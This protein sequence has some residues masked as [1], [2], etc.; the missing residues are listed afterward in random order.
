MPQKNEF[1]L[2]YLGTDTYHEYDLLYGAKGEFSV[3]IEITN[4]ITRYAASAVAYDEFHSIFTS[5]VKILG[6]G[7]LLQKQDVFS[8]VVYPYQEDDDYLQDKY[9]AHFAGREYTRISTYLT[10]T[11]QPKKGRF[12]VYD[13]KVLQE[14]RQAVTKVVSILGASKCHPSLLKK[15][16]INKLMISVL[17]MDFSGDSLVLDNIRPTDTELQMGS[18]ATRCI[19]LVNADNVDLPSEVGTHIEMNDKDTMKGFPVDV[20]NFLHKVPGYETIIYNQMIEIPSQQITLNKL[21]VKKKRHSGIPDPVNQL[22]VED[23]DHLLRDVAR[24]N[25]LLVRAHFNIMVTCKQE[26]LQRA[27][28]YIE[29]ALFGLGIIVSKNA[30]NQLEL[31]RTALP[32]NGVEIQHY[33]WFLTTCDAAL[34]L[35]FKESLPKDD[36]SKFLV[37][38]TDRQGIP[39][40]IDLSDLM[41][42]T[43]RISNRNRFV[44]GG[45]G[46]GKSFFINSLVE[47]Y[48]LF[49]MDV[50]IVDVGHSYTGLNQFKNG[51]YVTYTEDKPI[52]MNPFQIKADEYNIEKKDFL[53]TLTG[54]L[55]KGADGTISTVERDVISNVVSAYYNAYFNPLLTYGEDAAGEVT[56]LNFN[57]FYDFA[58]YKIPKIKSEDHIPFDLDEFR[59][60]LKKFYR[61]GEYETILNEAADESLFFEPFIIYEIDNVKDN[62]VLFP[63][64]TLIIMDVFIQKMRHRKDRRKT[65]ILEEAWKALASPIMAEFLLYLNKTVRKFWGEIIE[66]TQE[67]G[68]ILSNPIVKDS[69]INNSD[70]VILLDQSKALENFKEVAKLLSITET[71]Q[72]KIFTTNQ[73]DNKENRGL[74][75]EVY[76]RRGQVGEVYGVEVSIEQYLV[77]TTEKP[78]KSAVE[79]Y[80]RHYGKYTDGLDA[81][82][83]DLRQS[84][85]SLTE[86][87]TA[88]NSAGRPLT[89]T[90]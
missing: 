77:Y 25:Q 44:L 4:P 33:D 61:G 46:T 50:V 35:F 71:E 72:R 55:W 87:V 84:G 11:R 66:V 56:E 9:N 26:N 18:R 52:T 58:L 65:L 42:R 53:V 13:P 27:A 73:L 74:F 59:Y 86:F 85:K 51:K 79:I 83:T 8:K 43:G 40:G 57:S 37:R 70:T 76:I 39:I 24:D 60:V 30:Y 12:Y 47:Q 34:C 6:D 49:N 64:C 1:K 17:A 45:S 5:L 21:E 62:K 88:V 36:P 14:F 10:I 20:L 90:N 28:N 78:E 23:I 3:V 41:M 54:L 19:S 16:E 48:L 63:I 2:P 80:T 38:F 15:Q 89:I 67:L 81:F 69:I 7:Y 31:F 29:N 68:D 82:V 22:C 75:K 32:G